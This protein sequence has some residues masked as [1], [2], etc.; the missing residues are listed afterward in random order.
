MKE[1]ITNDEKSKKGCW[2]LE[3]DEFNKEDKKN[4]KMKSIR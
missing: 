1:N 4:E 2:K 3:K